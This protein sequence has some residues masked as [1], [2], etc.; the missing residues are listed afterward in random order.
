MFFLSQCCHGSFP[1]WGHI[2]P[3]LPRMP[4]NIVLAPGPVVGAAQIPIRSYSCVF[5][6]PTSTAITTSAFSF[7]GVLNVLLYI[8]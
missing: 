7:V 1:Y 4:C 3:H 8:P 2:P 5:L 6:P